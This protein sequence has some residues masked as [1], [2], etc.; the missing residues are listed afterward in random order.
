MILA[1]I[2]VEEEDELME[3]KVDSVCKGWLVG[4]INLTIPYILL[5]VHP[6][7]PE[8]LPLPPATR[9]TSLPCRTFHV[10]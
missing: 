6:S 4:D 2:V 9:A 1:G 10:N 7:V 3:R 5:W 8:Q